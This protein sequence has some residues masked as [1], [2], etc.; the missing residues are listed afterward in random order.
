[1]LQKN[2]NTLS[3]LELAEAIVVGQ[4]RVAMMQNSVNE[5]L[6]ELQNRIDAK[7]AEKATP[8]EG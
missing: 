3:D 1:M 8:T 2:T 5:L 7:K 4:Q 6:S